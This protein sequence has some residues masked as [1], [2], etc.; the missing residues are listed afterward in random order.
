MS[1]KETLHFKI[2]LSGSSTKKQPE[3][4]IS[5]NNTEFVSAQLIGDANVTEYFEFD[6]SVDEGECSLVIELVNKSMYDTVLDASGNIVEDLLLNIDSVEVDEIDLG[7]LLWTASDYRPNYP[8]KHKLKVTQSGQELPE[9]VKNCVN[10]GWNGSWILS[11]TS[12]FYIWLLE[13]I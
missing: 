6:A 12:P 4:K 3:F 11:F 9:S 1:D 13:N 7:S 2:G 10:L 8:E 5:V